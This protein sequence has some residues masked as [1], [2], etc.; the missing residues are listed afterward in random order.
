MLLSDSF[1]PMGCSWN[2]FR[3]FLGGLEV[4]VTTCL[5]RVG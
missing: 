3:L 2:S 4:S 5:I 1:T